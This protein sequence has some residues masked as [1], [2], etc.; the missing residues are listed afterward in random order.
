MAT[1]ATYTISS[2]PR[3][4]QRNHG[5]LFSYYDKEVPDGGRYCVLVSPAIADAVKPGVQF[6]DANLRFDAQLNSGVLEL[7]FP[8]PQGAPGTALPPDPEAGWGDPDP[9]LAATDHPTPAL[10]P[11]SRRLSRAH[12]RRDAAHQAVLDQVGKLPAALIT[13]ADEDQRVFQY[14][15][16]C[17]ANIEPHQRAATAREMAATTI[18]NWRKQQGIQP[19]GYE[20]T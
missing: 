5:W 1:M 16:A 6:T 19:S 13:M 7:E 8:Q 3:A 17:L 18:I 14:H 10:P 9:L 4:S 12:Q 2:H 20:S 15:Y 11:S